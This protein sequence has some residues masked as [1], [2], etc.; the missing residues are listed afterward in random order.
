MKTLFKQSTLALAIAAASTAA[1]AGDIDYTAATTG[2]VVL[3]NEV[4][5]TGS[6]ETLVA[7]PDVTYTIDAAND[8][9]ANTEVATVKFTL[10]SGAVFGEDLSDIA[11]W[12]DANA[13]LVFTATGVAVPVGGTGSGNAI[14]YGASNITGIEVDQGGAIG[15][16]TVT[17]TFT[18]TGA[19]TLD[20]VQVAGFR[21]KNL[22]SALERGVANP[23]VRLGAEFR[24]VD[25]AVTDTDTALVIFS[26]QDGVEL[27]GSATGYSE[28]GG[29]IATER[30]RIDVADTELSFTGS[31]DALIGVDAAQDFDE[32]NNVSFVQLGDLQVVRTQYEDALAATVNVK[33]E[34]ADDFDFNGSD[35]A[36]ISL[37]STSA[38]A[39]YSSVYLR[40][41]AD[42]L[43]TGTAAGTDFAGT[44]ATDGLSASF[45]LTGETTA[46]LEAGYNVCAVAGGTATVPETTFAAELA[47]EYFNPRYTDS[48]DNLD[49]GQLLR[50]GCQVTLFN[51]P[52]PMSGDKA[53]I[54]LTNVSEKPGAV[55]A[56]IW[57]QDG[58]MIDEGSELVD[59][60]AAHATTVLS[61]DTSHPGYI[62]DVMTTYASVNEGRH[63]IVLQGAFPACEALG[64][65][66]TPTGVLTNMTSTT[67][68]GDE[69][70]LGT[71]NNGTSNT[72]N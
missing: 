31:A 5:G 43:C 72:S 42:G 46:E 48:A 55:R 14:V 37:T 60:L 13:D 53:F 15:D 19:A 54:R 47:V 45:N 57:S 3:A 17:F 49:L 1:F 7:I 12:Q 36:T 40:P 28:D 44:V 20:T 63:R 61:S 69:T 11:K 67:Y 52:N 30:A 6:E 16:N 10:D 26:S 39:A 66:R 24:N 33:K 35:V 71:E 22:T 62:G 65:I 50:N 21:V 70:R 29:T 25:T 56:F 27:T 58:D 34:N 8:D 32:T 4:F 9:V 2:K 23:A 51:V 38:M 18:S 59:S 41:N 68:S 64:L